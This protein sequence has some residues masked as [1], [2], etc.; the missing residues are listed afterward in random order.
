M[1]KKV[2]AILLM[3]SMLLIMGNGYGIGFVKKA[4]AAETTLGNENGFL[5]ADKDKTATVYVDAGSEEVSTDG[6]HNY[7]GLKMIADTFADD[8]ASVT[9]KGSK[10]V[11]DTKDMS[12]NIIIAG[13]IG[14]NKVIDALIE[15]GAID[16]S[17]LYKDGELKW[18]CY[19]MQFVS[20]EALAGVGYSGVD[21][22]LVITGSNKRGAMYGLFHISERIGVSAWVYMADAYR[23][24]MALSIWTKHFW[25][26]INRTCILPKSHRSSTV[27]FLSMMNPR[28]LPAGLIASLA[29]SMKSVIKMFLNFS[30]A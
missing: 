28:R 27:D 17:G 14:H 15:K 13:T 10:V 6:E 25:S 18:D 20:G 16:S 23:I 30:F 22:A 7:C 21:K 11:T 19:Q 3:I 2:T 4:E 24:H 1:K 9:G 29:A 8:V 26:L 5:L 12:G